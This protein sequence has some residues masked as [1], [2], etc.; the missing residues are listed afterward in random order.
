MFKIIKL[1]LIYIFLLLSCQTDKEQC[2]SKEENKIFDQQFDSLKAKIEKTTD[3]ASCEKL[4]AQISSL[5]Q[6]HRS[7]KRRECPLHISYGPPT[8]HCAEDG[9]K[10]YIREEALQEELGATTDLKRIEE[11][12]TELKKN[13]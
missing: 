4:Q 11:I 5:V 7:K 12:K 2:L 13:I 10:R 1:L 3:K 8:H 9:Y 6:K